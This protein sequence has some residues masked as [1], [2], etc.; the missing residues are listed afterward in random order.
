MRVLLFFT[1]IYFISPAYLFGQGDLEKLLEENN[2]PKKQYV[3]SSFKGTRLIGLHTVE[4][5]GKGSLDFRISHRFGDFSSGAYN[6]FGLDGPANIRLGFDYSVTDNF[7]VGIGRSSLDKMFDSFLKY[8]LLRQTTD[9]SMPITLT[10]LASGNVIGL[11]NGSQALD[12][13]TQFDYFSDRLVYMFQAMVAR[14]FTERLTVQLSPIFI[15]YNLVLNTTDKNDMYAF[16]FSGRY[17]FSKRIALTA[18]YIPRVGKYSLGQS[19][20]HN[21]ASV[22][23]DIETGGH[24]FQ[25]FVANSQA[26]NEVQFIPYTNSSWGNG[27]V[28]FGFNISRVFATRRKR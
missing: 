6:F 12:G 23:I 1:I 9:N 2:T 16:A 13:I 27:Q 18:E 11:K 20:Y 15:H 14:K 21:S 7:T 24:V 25:L 8:R 3:Y 17:K 22:G 26:I 5:L 10:L 28:R 4:T 19:L